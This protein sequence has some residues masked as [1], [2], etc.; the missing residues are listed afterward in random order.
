MFNCCIGIMDHML[1]S[2]LFCCTMSTSHVFQVHHIHHDIEC[3]IHVRYSN[4][5]ELTYGL[6]KLNAL[7][8]LCG[9]QIANA[10][11]IEWKMC[12]ANARTHVHSSLMSLPEIPYTYRR[13]ITQSSRNTD[14]LFVVTFNSLLWDCG[15][16]DD[17]CC[18]FA[19][20]EHIKICGR[21]IEREIKKKMNQMNYLPRWSLAVRWLRWQDSS[22]NSQI[23]WRCEKMSS[24]QIEWIYPTTLL[25]LPI[26]ANCQ[27]RVFNTQIDTNND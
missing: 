17:E 11:D 14:I 1:L 10:I 27:V 13:I 26:D 6:N 2:L 20:A 18:P 5:F 22:M 19:I 16:C 7:N 8:L 24:M 12:T 3:P 21:K 15:G 4:F 23:T 9:T 25:H